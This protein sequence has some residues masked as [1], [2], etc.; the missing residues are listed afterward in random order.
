MSN[1]VPKEDI[2]ASAFHAVALQVAATLFRGRLVEKEVLF[3]GGPLGF[4]QGYGVLLWMFFGL[5]EK[6][7]IVRTANPELIAAMGASL[8]SS[9]SASTTSITSLLKK[10]EKVKNVQVT[11]EKLPPLFTTEEDFLYWQE[12]HQQHVVEKADIY[13]L[14]GEDC[15]LGIDSGST[16]TKIILMDHRNRVVLSHY[17]PN[18]GNPVKTVR[19]GL[20]L[21]GT[22]LMKFGIEIRIARTAVT[23]YGEDLIRAAFGIDD[24]I[25]ETM[26]HYRAARTF[27]SR[28]S[29]ILD[30]GGQDMKAIFINNDAVSNIQI[31]EACSSGCGSFIETFARSLNC[32]VAQ[33]AQLACQSEA[34]FDLGTRCTVFM[35]SKV[36]QAQ[37]EGASI[38]NIS[39]GL[40][41]AVVKNS[42]Y[43]VLKLTDVRL[44]GEHIVVQG[45]TF[46]NPAIL[47]AF[48]ILTGKEVIRPDIAELMGA[49]GAAITARDNY[50]SERTKSSSFV[51]FQ[52]TIEFGTDNR[53]I[54]TAR[55]VKTNA[56]LIG[57]AFPM[58]AVTL[59]EIG[60]RTSSATALESAK[61]ASIWWQPKKNCFLTGL[62]NRKGNR[63][64]PLGFPVS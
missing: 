35:N 51:G 6:T 62:L 18:N 15:F 29:F 27:S 20:L 60:V 14:N 30:I 13:T 59:R 56:G 39:A 61:K 9:N 46:R 22:T 36:K 25:V 37:S 28:V 11:T 54:L 10:L 53:E 63:Y 44:L 40:A 4:F 49:Y 17:S 52:P 16:T 47:R 31:N 48:E 1:H 8:Y 26:A 57:F 32:D 5:D 55:D 23:G 42:L 58:D 2:V 33:F 7:D 24:G 12:R 19:S 21:F 41:Y 64:F 3:G 50:L 38:S 34:P 45:G 43:K